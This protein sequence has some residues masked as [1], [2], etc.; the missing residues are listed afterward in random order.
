MTDYKYI[1]TF[2]CEKKL[3]S[4]NTPLSSMV[5]IWPLNSHL[6]FYKPVDSFNVLNFA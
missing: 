6:I 1:K 3:K 4:F 2:N 5:F